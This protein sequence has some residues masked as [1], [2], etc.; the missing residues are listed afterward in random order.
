MTVPRSL[1]ILYAGLLQSVK[2]VISVRLACRGLQANGRLTVRTLHLRATAP[3]PHLRSA[4]Q[5]SE[6]VL[7]SRRSGTRCQKPFRKVY[8][9]RQLRPNRRMKRGTGPQDSVPSIVFEKKPGR[10]SRR[11][12]PPSAARCPSLP[13][14]GWFQQP[15]A[16]VSAQQIAR[17]PC[18][19]FVVRPSDLTD[20]APLRTE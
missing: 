13:S 5:M 2:K 19:W 8:Q 17:F 12:G 15:S 4:L 16:S 18:V 9:V 7:G 11:E 3:E 14:R 20:A 1:R 6:C 10:G